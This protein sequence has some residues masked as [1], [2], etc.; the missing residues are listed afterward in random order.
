MKEVV[1][2]RVRQLENHVAEQP[3]RIATISEPL[4]VIE[5]G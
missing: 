2:G 1:K 5:R 4:Q 3:M